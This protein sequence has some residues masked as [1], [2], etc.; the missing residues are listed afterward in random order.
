[1]RRVV[2]VGGPGAGKTTLAGSVAAAIDASHVELDSLWW[3]RGWVPRSAE[4]L[5][6]AVAERLGERWVVDG[7]Y[8]EEVGDLVWPAADV[9]VWLDLPRRTCVRRAV[10]RALRRRVTGQEL[11][12]GNRESWSVLTPRSVW[13]LWHRWPSY[14]ARVAARLATHDGAVVRLRTTAEVRHWLS[15][16]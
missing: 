5:R 3:Q 13:R 7:F 2:V 4:E 6:A 10:V 9:V 15:T 11:W 12:N 16:L 8:V 14:P 1:V